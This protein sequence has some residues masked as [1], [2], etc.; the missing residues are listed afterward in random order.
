MTAIEVDGRAFWATTEAFSVW[1]AYLVEEIGNRAPILLDPALRELGDEWR[2]QAVAPEFGAE[3]C[4][5]SGRQRAALHSIAV[6]ARA[7]AES[8]GDLSDEQIRRWAV[9]DGRPVR[10]AT[11]VVGLAQVLEV[12]DGF[13][14]LLGNVFPPDP[15]TDEFID[16]VGPLE[17]STGGWLLG[18]GDGYQPFPARATVVHRARFVSPPDEPGPTRRTTSSH[19]ISRTSFFGASA[20]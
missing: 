11:S 17:N 19:R 4:G 3:A 18:I 5:L 20:Q 6:A 16:L 10:S 12:A 15:P 8:I 13:I 7:R 9:F 14:A 2:R 1:M